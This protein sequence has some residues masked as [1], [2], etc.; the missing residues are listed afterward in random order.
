MSVVV[1]PTIAGV[2]PVGVRARP[3]GDWQTIVFKTH[4]RAGFR[5]TL[6]AFGVVRRRPRV[7][8]VAVF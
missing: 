6:A 7:C 3:F 8:S 4:V 1:R 2:G 5:T